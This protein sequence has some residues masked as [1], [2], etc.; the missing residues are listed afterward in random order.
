MLNQ[1]T[2]TYLLI[3]GCFS[4]WFGS[5]SSS[6]ATS[7]EFF[8]EAEACYQKL[9]NNSQKQKYRYNW[10]KCIDKSQAVY[11]ADPTGPWAAAGLYMSGNL[12]YELYK[13]SGQR[14]DK[15]EAIDHFNRIVKRFPKSGYYD[16]AKK[17]IRTASRDSKKTKAKNQSRRKTTA[18]KS[19]SAKDKFYRAEACY[20]ALQN[21][22]ARQKYR[23]KWLPCIER[24]ETAYRADPSGPWA[25]ASLYYS[26]YLY[27]ELYRR[28]Y[29]NGDKKKAL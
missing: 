26:G 11:R 24:F 21:N 10:V 16:R 1:K 15:E 6:A 5:E 28:S 14:A 20:Q 4:I 23:D 29:K 17:A 13:R 27:Y 22:P 12:Y 18:D 3:I 25:A 7:R 19:T 9:R 2:L 8:F